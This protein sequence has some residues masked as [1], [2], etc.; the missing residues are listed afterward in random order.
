MKSSLNSQ[1][2]KNDQLSNETRD[3]EAL[4]KAVKF[5]ISQTQTQIKKEH[6]VFVNQLEKEKENF[7][8][9]DTEYTATL[10]DINNQ[11]FQ[12]RQHM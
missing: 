3:L 2:D 10:Q 5:E 1:Y 7:R 11:T 6:Q 4:V 9:V 12:Q 8:E